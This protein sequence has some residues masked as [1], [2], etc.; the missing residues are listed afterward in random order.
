MDKISYF[1]NNTVTCRLKTGILES[2][3]AS[4]AIQWLGSHVSATIG[5]ANALLSG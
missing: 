5:A 4:I 3:R 2:E 1:W